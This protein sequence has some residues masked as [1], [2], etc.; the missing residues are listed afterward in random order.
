MYIGNTN[1]KRLHS[2]DCRAVKMIAPKHI[3]YTED[4]EGF[5][6]LEMGVKPR[7]RKGGRQ[8]I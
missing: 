5:H 7:Y 6:V 1:T 4:G 2:P 8:W 3:Q